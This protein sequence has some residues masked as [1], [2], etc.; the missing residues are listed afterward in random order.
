MRLTQSAILFCD[1][2]K[3]PS[4]G[5]LKKTAAGYPW[6]QPA[7]GATNEDTETTEVSTPAHS[8]VAV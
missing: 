2:W 1:D 7:R 6:A 5:L 4:N 3:K 8:P